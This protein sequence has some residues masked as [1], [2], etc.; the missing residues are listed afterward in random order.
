MG[1]L[2]W[3]LPVNTQRKKSTM[4]LFPSSSPCPHCKKPMQ[5]FEKTCPH[6]GVRLMLSGFEAAA[7]AKNAKKQSDKS[8]AT[9]GLLARLLKC[10]RI[11]RF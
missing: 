1:V 4:A 7:Q 9:G 11:S 3:R 10:L 8:R 2:R 5:C 6:C